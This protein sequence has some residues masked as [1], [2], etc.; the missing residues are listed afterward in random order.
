MHPTKRLPTLSQQSE[1]VMNSYS[2]SDSGQPEYV[3]LKD[4]M[5]SSSTFDDGQH[6]RCCDDL[7]IKNPLL[8][9]ASWVYLRSLFHSSKISYRQRPSGN[10][11]CFLEVLM[12]NVNEF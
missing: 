8:Q 3:S 10:Q 2:R 6:M 7:K 4:I 9:R 1:Y 11:C 12:E 5:D